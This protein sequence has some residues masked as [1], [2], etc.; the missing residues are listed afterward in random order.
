MAYEIHS[1]A[2]CECLCYRRDLVWRKAFQYRQKTYNLHNSF[3]HFSRG[4]IHAVHSLGRVQTLLHDMKTLTQTTADASHVYDISLTSTG[5]FQFS[6]DKSAYG[7]I[8]ED[9]IRTLEGEMQLDT[10]RGIPYQR[11]I[12]QSL[13]NLAVWE[14][15]VR[16]AVNK[17]PFVVNI[18]SLDASVNEGDVLS[19]TMTILTDDGTVE[20]SS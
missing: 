10:E 5:D 7:M 1:N 20:V 2:F 11:T 16:E 13:R 17:Y 15:F 8:L 6:T 18:E 9:A 19:Y 4:D 12:W 3:D 14:I